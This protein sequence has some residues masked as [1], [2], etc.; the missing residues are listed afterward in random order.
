MTT[1]NG[2]AEMRGAFTAEGR[3]YLEASNLVRAA[4]RERRHD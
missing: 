4:W 1:T 3:V 2:R